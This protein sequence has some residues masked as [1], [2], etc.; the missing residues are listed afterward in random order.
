MSREQVRLAGKCATLRERKLQTG[1]IV[2]RVAGE[3]SKARIPH[4]PRKKGG[5]DDHG[6]AAHIAWSEAMRPYYLV[7][8]NANGDGLRIAKT[9]GR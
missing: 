5:I 9:G 4:E 7:A 6:R 1:A 8:V 2:K 3:R